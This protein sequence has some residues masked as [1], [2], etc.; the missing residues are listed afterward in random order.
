[1]LAGAVLMGSCLAA[2]EVPAPSCLLMDAATGTILYEENAHERLAPASVTKV[3]TAAVGDGGHRRRA[4]LSWDDTVTA[5]AAAA[6][7]GGSQVYLEEGEQMSVRDMVKSVRGLL[8]QRLRYGPGRGH[9]RLSDSGFVEK[10]NQRAHGAGH[11]R[12]PHFVNCTGLDDDAGAKEHLH[13]RLG[14][15]HDVAGSS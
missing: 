5:S 1:M 6:A 4:A 2:P 10:M 14:H 11:G 13:Q 3:M 8:G 15:R 12:T 7:K 9:R